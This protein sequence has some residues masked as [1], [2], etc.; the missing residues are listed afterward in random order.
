MV[1]SIVDGKLLAVTG[2]AAFLLYKILSKYQWD[3][4][5]NKSPIDGVGKASNTHWLLGDSLLFLGPFVESQKRLCEDEIDKKGRLA[6]WALCFGQKALV[7]TDWNDARAVLSASSFRNPMGP[8]RRHA[9]MLLGKRNIGLLHG[10][11]WKFHRAA[12]TRSFNPVTLGKRN[13]HESIVTVMDQLFASLQSRGKTFQME[14]VPLMKMVTVDVFGMSAFRKDFG[15]CR[16]LTPSRVSVAFDYMSDEFNRRMFESNFLTTLTSVYWLPTASN[17]RY[18]RER[19]YIRGLLTDIIQEHKD[20]QQSTN[21][22]NNNNVQHDEDLL[23]RMIQ[24]HRE[25]QEQ[26]STGVDDVS[27]ETITDILMSVLFAG[28]DTSS[29]TLAY[30]LY[31]I[32][33]HPD[34]EKNVLEEIA[35]NGIHDVDSLPYCKAVIMETLRLF[36]PGMLTTRNMTKDFQFRDGLVVPTDTVAVVPIWSIQRRAS[37]FPRPL[38]FRPDRWAHRINN[39]NHDDDGTKKASKGNERQGLSELWKERDDEPGTIP[40]GNRKAFLAFSVGGRSCAGYKFA[41]QEVITIF[42]MLVQK[43]RFSVADD[44]VLRPVRSGVV[45]SPNDGLPMTMEWRDGNKM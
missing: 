18:R 5:R 3:I 24:T 21:D 28:Y 1:E 38:E 35:A 32:A 39:N 45:Q 26:G 16:T 22:N 7:V 6:I 20:R 4:L 10:N 13:V 36:P 8:I 9:G 23:S 44:F 2:A 31:H 15:S 19:N 40:P 14:L 17:L 37:N 41:M 30:A 11:E 43:L 27:N 33:K 42:A 25:L 34:I 12:I 29:V